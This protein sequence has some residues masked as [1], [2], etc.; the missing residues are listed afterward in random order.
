MPC[1]ATARSRPNSFSTTDST[2]T[3]ARFVA[4][5]RMILFMDTSKGRHP[6]I[7]ARTPRYK[8]SV[9]RSPLRMK[10]ASAGLLRP[11]IAQRDG[12]VEHE[13]AR[14]VVDEVGDE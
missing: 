1:A 4:T 3:T 10:R 8:A 13:P 11:G 14:M 2:S 7:S 9:Q 6:N 12:P 5:N